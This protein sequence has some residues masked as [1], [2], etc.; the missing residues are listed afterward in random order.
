[1]VRVVAGVFLPDG[2]LLVGVVAVGADVD[3]DFGD[4]LAVL[5]GVYVD[6]EGVAGV[7]LG[8]VEVDVEVAE[9]VDLVAQNVVFRSKGGVV[10]AE[11]AGASRDSPA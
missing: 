6:G 10:A 5:V 3:V 2:Q 8:I 7:V 4:F 1:M 9:G 11:P